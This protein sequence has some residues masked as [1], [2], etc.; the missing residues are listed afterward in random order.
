MRGIAAKR[1]KKV[2]HG[3]GL[4]G[5]RELETKSEKI[6]P[7]VAMTAHVMDGDREMCLAAG[8]DDYISK[9]I[10]PDKL[11]ECISKYI[12]DEQVQEQNLA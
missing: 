6:T 8:M 2:L 12:K 4:R 11:R 9:P 5:F 10:N 3:F 7:I 1:R